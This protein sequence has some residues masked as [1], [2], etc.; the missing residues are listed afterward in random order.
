MKFTT[1]LAKYADNANVLSLK[2]LAHAQ[3]QYMA[4]LFAGLSILLFL[5][6]YQLGYNQ[7]ESL[8][9]KLFVV[10][11]GERVKVGDIVAFGWDG[12]GKYAWM[13][14]FKPGSTMVKYV[15]GK[16]GDVIRTDIDG[17]VT[18][19][20]HPHAKAK[21]FT[22]AGKPL[23]KLVEPGEYKEIGDH[24]YYVGTPHPDGFDSRYEMVGLID[25]GRF[26]GKVYAIF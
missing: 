19:N 24:Q 13:S 22:K 10:H 26:L 23:K 15:M 6:N 25:E 16:P 4:W 14:P 7:T 5:Q 3:R 17:E 18:L 20:G 2:L 9:Y 21:E 1:S 11:K 8:P 12:G